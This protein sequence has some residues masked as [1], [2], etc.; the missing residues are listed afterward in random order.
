MVEIHAENLNFWQTGQSSPDTWIER[1][2]SQIIG[3]GGKIEGEGFGSNSEGKAAY[4]I[5]FSIEGN[6]FK[7]IWPVMKSKTNNQKAAKIQAATS[8][9]HYVKTI[10]LYAVVVGFRTAFFSHLMLPGGK[11]A[12]QIANEEIIK[13]IPEMLLYSDRKLLK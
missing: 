7:V 6:A 5:G 11:I 1:A 9:Y 12:S 3:L 13:L 10:C 4:M 8:L 2:K